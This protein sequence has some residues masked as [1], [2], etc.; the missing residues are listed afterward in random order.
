[1]VLTIK[2]NKIENEKKFINVKLYG[3]KPSIVT[4]PSKKGAKNITKNLLF[5]KAVK[6]KSLLLSN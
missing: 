6:I 2:N 3:E 5:N 4:A 1:M